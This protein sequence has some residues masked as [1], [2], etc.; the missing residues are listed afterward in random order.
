MTPGVMVVIRGEVA[1][2]ATRQRSENWRRSLQQI[3]DK[4]GAIE[5]SLSRAAIMRQAA[6]S[7]PQAPDLIWRVRLLD[8][9]EQN[10]VVEAPAAMGA[11]IPFGPGAQ[12]VAAI[13]IGQ[14]RWMFETRVHEVRSDPAGPAGAPPSLILEA[15]VSVERCHRRQSNRISTYELHLPH[16]TVWPLL[17]LDSAVVAERANELMVEEAMAG[18][19]LMIAPGNPAEQHMMLP[20][21]GPPFEAMIANLGGGGMGLVIDPKNARGV[22]RHRLFWLRFSLPPTIPAPLSVTAR[23][24]HSH[25]DSAQRTYA[26]LAFEFGHNRRHRDFLLARIFEYV[27]SLQEAQGVVVRKSA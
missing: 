11:A 27:A 21:V 26:G 13:V 18:G 12:I 17:D 2:P 10:L 4:R 25:I 23:M 24:V 3:Y 8:V 14:N 6:G 7:G 15:P 1:V 16:C 20:E 19:R 22:E 5:I 9:G